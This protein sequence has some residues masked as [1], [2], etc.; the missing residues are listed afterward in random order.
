MPKKEAQSAIYENLLDAD[1]MEADDEEVIMSEE[2]DVSPVDDSNNDEVI[3]EY[4]DPAQ[5]TIVFTLPDVPGAPDAEEIVL[6][7]ENDT[8][9]L[10]VEEEEEVQ[11]V[12]DP[13]DWQSL[14]LENYLRWL[15]EM[16][17][18]PPQHT[19]YDSTGLEKAIAYYQFLEKTV[20]K[21][22]RMDI[23][24]VIDSRLAEQAREQIYDAIVRLQNRLQQV[25]SKKY[26]V[27]KKSW[28]ES[29]G[30]IKEGQKAPRITG[31]TVTVPLI[32]SR[33]ARVCINGMVS[34]GH[35]IEDLFDGQVKEYGL[36][37][38]QQAELAQL[39]ADMGYPMRQDRGFAVGTH[40]DVTRSDNRDWAANYQA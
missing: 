9:D 34:A 36:D 32:I 25:N 19:G 20:P 29:V 4:N 16:M 17:N 24:N 31:I 1:V 8:G 11:V 39:L 3:L 40:V 37:K 12:S 35:D 21:A 27:K 23:K 6:D 5:E 2:H 13:W 26:K 30:I 14:G 18:N 15:H 28:A 22:M 33:C 10:E 7:D 38:I